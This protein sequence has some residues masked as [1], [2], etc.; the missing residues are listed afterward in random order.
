MRA[1]V[2]YHVPPSASTVKPE[3]QSFWRLIPAW[4]PIQP[5]QLIRSPT[6][7]SWWGLDT[8]LQT[9]AHI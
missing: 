8:A 7:T 6:F 4:G 5:Y 1:R 2:R 9:E 3:G